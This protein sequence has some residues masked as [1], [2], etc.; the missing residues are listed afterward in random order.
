MLLMIIK[1]WIK[2]SFSLAII[3]CLFVETKVLSK[4]Q[5]EQL[6]SMEQEFIAQWQLS[7]KP[8]QSKAA[9]AQQVTAICNA[10]Q[11]CKKL[12]VTQ[13]VWDA[14][15]VFGFEISVIDAPLDEVKA[16]VRSFIKKSVSLVDFYLIFLFAQRLCICYSGD[17]LYKYMYIL[18]PTQEPLKRQ[19][20]QEL[21]E[22]YHHRYGIYFPFYYEE[23][24]EK[25][26]YQSLSSFIDSLESYT[27]SQAALLALDPLVEEYAQQVLQVKQDFMQAVAGWNKV[28]QF[29][30]SEFSSLYK[31]YVKNFRT[32][33]FKPLSVYLVEK[34]SLR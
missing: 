32:G 18:H 10:L 17:Q 4:D 6:T 23:I 19:I 28:T 12:L 2:F 8:G 26:P 14:G 9:I 25:F 34:K 29:I 16:L 22:I 11:V 27:R 21:R 20:V 24:R 1:I 3:F 13:E 30:T 5:L 33:E 7:P 15:F 31:R